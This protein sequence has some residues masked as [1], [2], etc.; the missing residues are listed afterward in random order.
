[1]RL[2]LNVIGC[3]RPRQWSKNVLIF[4]AL[5]FS[6]HAFEQWYLLRSVAAFLLFSLAAGTMYIFNDIKDIE[7][8][9]AHPVKRLRPIP[10]GRITPSAAG[11]AAV[12]LIS[13]TLALSWLLDLRF[14]L[15]M[16][17]YAV[18]QV[19]YTVRL[20]HIVI[21][22]VFIVATGFVLRVI[23]GAL[24]INVAISNW[25]LI[26]TMLLA[27]FLVL[28]KRRNELTHLEGNAE[29]HRL[30]LREYSPYLLDQMIGVVTAA[31]LVT[32]MVYTLDGDTVAKFGP[33]GLVIT[34]PFVLYGIFRYL[35][36]IHQKHE[37]GHPEELFLTDMPLQLAIL[38][39]IVAALA[40]IYL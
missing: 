9:R 13:G 40:A 2:I 38:G 3:L 14:G 39:Y 6:Q 24:V 30:I 28:A 31:T 1:M 19:L 34:T 7:R 35:Y 10:D 4:A 18:L 37:G 5:V 27:L 15:V 16:T 22:D 25:I 29:N 21:L 11:A 8:D 20:K 26:C 36:L 32:Y 33:H 12:V 23:A 17:I